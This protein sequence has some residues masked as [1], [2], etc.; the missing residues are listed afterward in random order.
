MNTP[1]ITLPKEEAEEHYKEYLEVVKT[2]KEKYLD[3]LKKTYYHLSK[4]RRVLDIYEVF[5]NCGVDK[6]GEP[7]L[8]IAPASAKEI[9]FEKFALGS[10]TFTPHDRWSRAEKA[11]VNLPTKTF[12]EWA[13][14]QIKNSYNSE[15]HEGVI[16]ER[17]ITNVPIVPA[18]ILPEGSLDNYYVLFE[19]KEWTEPQEKRVARKGDPYLLKRIN[20]NTFA[21]MAEWDVTDVELAVLRGV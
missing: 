10:G 20:Q 6:N 18:H 2:R 12:G 19:V 4:E 17:V 14:G 5:K 21:I 9:T 13:R 8:A 15:T 3:D 11:D 7:K 16:R 1:I